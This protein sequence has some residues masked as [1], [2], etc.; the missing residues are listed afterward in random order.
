M[1]ENPE[2][3]NGFT[4]AA[5]S[6]EF[7]EKAAMGMRIRER[8]RPQYIGWTFSRK[9]YTHILRGFSYLRLSNTVDEPPRGPAGEFIQG[10]GDPIIPY[11]A[12][13]DGA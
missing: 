11:L 1:R 8:K 13:S 5:I 10:L 6:F 2:P 9:D 3:T 12:S 7:W 4:S